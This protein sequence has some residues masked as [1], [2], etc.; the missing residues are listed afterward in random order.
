MKQM[1]MRRVGLGLFLG[2]LIV[3]LTS[4][5]ALG[6][7]SVVL[8]NDTTAAGSVDTIG[9]KITN[10][11]ELKSVVIPLILRSNP[12]TPGTFITALSASRNPFDRFTKSL[13]GEGN[14][15]GSL[16]GLSSINRF[17]S[18]TAG[19]PNCKQG[20]P[21]GFREPVLSTYTGPWTS[22]AAVIFVIG[23]FDP[24]D[25]NDR[26]L[27]PGTD[28]TAVGSLRLIVT[29]N[30][31][32]G[33]FEV[34]T[35]C[36]TPDNH[37]LFND[38]LFIHEGFGFQPAFTK[39]FIQVG[40]VSAVQDLGGDGVPRD[41][42][43]EQNYPNPF[44]AGTVIKFNIKHDGHV[45]LDVFNILGQKV[46]TLV[47]KFLNYGPK[48]ADWDGTDISGRPVS[49]GLYFYRLVTDD[50]TDVKKMVLIK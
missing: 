3:G 19:S 6:V 22:P 2:V 39:C 44:N 31:T 21:G 9:I 30:N 34:D 37:L 40:S 5:T 29:V 26:L 41:F 23:Q 16:F 17:A 20:Q 13:D 38:T 15:L 50:Y 4:A 12:L 25:P 11:V 14:P 27:A 28:S 46:T 24:T 8:R 45:R 43:L 47:D 33:R 35:T 18:D 10:D 48:A 32:G 1:M 36:T 42:N 7:N 49:T